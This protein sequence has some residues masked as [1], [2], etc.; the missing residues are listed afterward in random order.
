[1][2]LG[3][4]L[5]ELLVR[6]QLTLS[7]AESCTG[8]L[9]CHILTNIPGASVWFKGG[10]IAYSNRAKVEMLN[11]R[12]DL[13]AKYGA[14]SSYV[15]KEM[16]RG[17]KSRFGTRFSLSATGIAGP[18]GGSR[19]KPVGLVYLGLAK[20]RLVKSKK[21]LFVGERESIKAQAAETAISWALKFL[22]QEGLL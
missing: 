20:D 14:V 18:A 21:C 17:V 7:V 22:S 8:G 5:A 6:K 13:L 10:V 15:A 4:E 1:M 19:E 11:V 12:E 9:I 3:A 2:S 16:A